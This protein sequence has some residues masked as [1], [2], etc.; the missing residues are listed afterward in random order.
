[1]QLLHGGTS[2]DGATNDVWATQDALTWLWVAGTVGQEMHP[3]YPDTFSPVY[4]SGHCQDSN[5][6]QY[7]AG[8]RSGDLSFSDV[9][10]S[11][12]GF[13][14]IEQTSYAEFEPRYL[15]SMTGD[16]NGYIY[17]A[18]GVLDASGP[19]RRSSSEVWMSNNQGRTGE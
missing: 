4:D 6:R 7:R 11:V 18:G 19:T 15:P 14:W 13:R 1:V 5:H 12:D 9:W 16:T 2:N 8:G 17:L 10:M 3:F